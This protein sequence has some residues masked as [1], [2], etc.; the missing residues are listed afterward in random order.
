MIEASSAAP[1]PAHQG[2]SGQ[3]KVA[4]RPD[5]ETGQQ[6]GLAQVVADAVR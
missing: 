4:Q 6:R 1:R 5:A 3:L 2:S